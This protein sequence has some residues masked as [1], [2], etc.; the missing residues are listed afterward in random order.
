[1]TLQP[2]LDSSS[3]I[4]IHVAAALVALFLGSAILFR[5]KGT[6]T[7]RLAGRIWVAALAVTALSSFA[8]SEIEVWGRWSPIHILSIVTLA[9]LAIGVDQARRGNIAAHRFTMQAIFFGGLA[10]A[11]LFTMLPG[12]LMHDVAFGGDLRTVVTIIVRSWSVVL[13]LAILPAALILVH[14]W[15]NR[16]HGSSREHDT[17]RPESPKF[18]GNE[19]LPFAAKSH[20]TACHDRRAQNPTR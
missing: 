3:A 18:K 4:Q 1:M 8:I 11:G 7:H 10:V 16:V 5:R 13:W 2:L 9:S 15:L 20:Y 17:A 14:R 12:R 6:T 19:P